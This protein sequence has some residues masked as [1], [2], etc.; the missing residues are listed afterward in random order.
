MTEIDTQKDFFL[1]PHG[2]MGLKQ[3][4]TDVLIA[5]GCSEAKITM[6]VG[7]KV[8]NVGDYMVQ[9]WPPGPT[10][11]QIKI[12]QITKVEEVEPEGMVGLWKGVSKE[13]VE[14]IPLE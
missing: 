6:G 10:P 14:S 5:K 9:L 2:N 7:T 11:N 1:F 4:V 12:Q 3:K 8:G 13:D